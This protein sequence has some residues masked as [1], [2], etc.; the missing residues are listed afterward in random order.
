MFDATTYLLLRTSG[1]Y[2]DYYY[3][4]CTHSCLPTLPACHTTSTST[5]LTYVPGRR[6]FTPTDLVS[7][8]NKPGSPLRE[9]SHLFPAE[10]TTHSLASS[11]PQIPHTIPLSCPFFLQ[12]PNFFFSLHHIFRPRNEQLHS[13]VACL[14]ARPFSKAAQSNRHPAPF[15]SDPNSRVSGLYTPS[16][17]N[18]TLSPRSSPSCLARAHLLNTPRAARLKAAILPTTRAR[19]NTIAQ[20]A[21]VTIVRD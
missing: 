7:Y 11:S 6:L 20:P 9:R 1:H 4:H 15:F 3:L 12:T 8:N 5:Y 14:I 2:Y 21:V 18:K 17:R 16:N 19:R 10:S 13:T